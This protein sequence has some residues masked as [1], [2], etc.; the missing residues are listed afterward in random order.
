MNI[1]EERALA[2]M[3]RH[4][5]RYE[6]HG[7]SE[8]YEA[9]SDLVAE[10]PELAA[11]LLAAEPR[12]RRAILFF[13]AAQY[14]LR[15]VA[16]E[17][18]LAA[19]L[20]T[21]GGD[22]AVDDALPAALSDF[23]DAHRDPL[24]VLCATR[25]TQTNEARRAALLRPGFGRAAE[26]TPGRPLHLVEVGTSAGL[27]L[28]T[29]R[30]ACRYVAPDR[31]ETYGPPSAPEA[32]TMT[33]AVRGGGWPGPAAVDPPV[34]G[35]VG[36]DLSPID[37][38]DPAATDWLRACVWPEQTDRL[39]RLDAALAELARLRPRLLAGDMVATLPAVLASVGPDAVPCVFASNALTYL[40]DAGR[41]E[42]V[43]LLD[44]H[45]AERDL[46]VVL[47]EASGCGAELFLAARPAEAGP[48]GV[49]A[50]GLL[51][52][53]TWLGGH[54]RVEV[55]GRTGPHGQWLEWTSRSS[56]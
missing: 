52:V 35:R 39:A 44:R 7:H 46:T 41:R 56:V 37:A 5:A 25:T 3:F 47:N 17:H 30:Y 40:D 11:P 4:F 55:L 36:I 51:T 54:R 20:P 23:I 50:V 1:T 14:L 16:P 43:D 29:D 8:R 53:V 21:L 19:Y 26:L 27:L 24:T 12:Q 13:A 33:C 49:L 18:P 48:P 32:L 31:T 45:G 22:R 6:F 9:L 42:L 10:R 38:A 2:D 15:T 28:I 34:A